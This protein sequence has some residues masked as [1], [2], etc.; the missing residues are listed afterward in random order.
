MPW[1][2]SG[3]HP[4]GW[5]AEKDSAAPGQQ[6]FHR[7]L[8]FHMAV[9]I[10]SP[11][12]VRFL[13]DVSLGDPNSSESLYPP[14]TS[15]FLLWHDQLPAAH[16]HPPPSRPVA[17]TPGPTQDKATPAQAWPTEGVSSPLSLLLLSQ[18]SSARRRSSFSSPGSCHPPL[19]SGQS[20]HSRGTRAPRPVLTSEAERD[21]SVRRH[22]FPH[23]TGLLS[24]ASDFPIPRR[25]RR[26]SRAAG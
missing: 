14:Q 12:A 10:S 22:V 25:Q 13:R 16:P 20:K 8:H 3:P 7:N 2:L 9:L 6:P 4:W 17:P 18:P 5:G 21:S 1:G 23:N 24:T 26:L 19:R 15:L 11:L